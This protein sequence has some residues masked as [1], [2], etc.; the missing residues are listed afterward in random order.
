MKDRVLILGKG[1]LGERLQEAFHCNISDRKIYSFQDAEEEIEKYKPK[2]IINCIGSTGAR[3]VDDCELDKEKTLFANT[4]VPIILAEIALRHKMKLVHIS[5][6]CIY[7][8]DYDKDRPIG[9]EKI[10]DFHYLFYS[11]GKV[12][13]ERALEVFCNEFNVLIPRIRIPLDNRPHPK[14]IL[15]KLIQYKRVI[16]LPNSVTYIPD[17]IK[18]LEHLM[19]IDAK[20]IYNVVNKDGLRY[21]DLLMVY[22]KHVPHFEYEV[23]D[24]RILNIVR[25]NLIM[26]T[27]KLENTGF[28]IRGIHEVL[29]ECVEGYTRGTGQKVLSTLPESN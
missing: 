29:E 9:E 23:I 4:F 16:D 12:Y 15:N 10:P 8:F 22:K 14:N 17:F 7:Q 20:G 26:S 5:S 21:P 24:Y 3:N 28:P 6:G 11:R 1:F 27:E 2:T 13:A 25:T 19:R 18:A